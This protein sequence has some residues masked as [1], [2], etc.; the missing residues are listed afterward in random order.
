MH[1]LLTRQSNSYPCLFDWT[2][3]K[4]WRRHASLLAF[5][6]LSPSKPGGGI[7]ICRIINPTMMIAG[8]IT[9]K[10][11]YGFFFTIILSCLLLSAPAFVS[12]A[13][14]Q[15]P[16]KEQAVKKR[17]RRTPALRP[18]VFKRLDEVREYTD[19]GEPGKALDKLASLEKM[20]RNSYEKAMTYNMYAY[21]YFNQEKY[22]DALANYEKVLTIDTIPESLE[23]TTRYTVAKLHLMQEQYDKALAM[24]NSWFESV[25]NPGEEAYIL[26]A[27]MYYQL[28][29][30]DKALPD[31]KQ[32]I[33]MTLEKGNVPRENWLLLE[34]A[35][36]YNN[37]DFVAMERCLKNLVTY[38]P[39][40]QY[41]VQL[42]AVYH[43]L[44]QTDKE[45]STLETAYEQNLLTQERQVVSLAQAMLMKEIPYKAAEILLQ[46]IKDGVVEESARNLSLLGDAFMLAKEYEQALVMMEKAAAISKAATDYYKLAQIYTERQQWS[47]A[48]NNINQALAAEE[49]DDI[50]QAWILKGL[51]LFNMNRLDRARTAFEKA[52]QYPQAEKMAGQ[53]LQ[54]IANEEKRRAYMAG[55]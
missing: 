15:E 49:L 52:R 13:Q 43:E 16:G 53:W 1:I 24:I 9:N 54:Y 34:R 20:P 48:L 44:G 29:Q 7:S 40:A 10:W 27:Q 17:V 55:L 26:R 25:G 33:A 46:G 45:L 3:L 35:V 51:V 2:R 21:V 32:A 47:E 38:Y 14:A 4:C 19:A 8:L 39:K 22:S 5:Q 28:E 37:A 23:Q 31:V 11:A 50:H 12:K 42:S 41:W 18:I 36:Y 30:F 6:S